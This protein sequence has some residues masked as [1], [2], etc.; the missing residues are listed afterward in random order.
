VDNPCLRPYIWGY[1]ADLRT[2]V[3]KSVTNWTGLRITRPARPGS[4]QGATK[5]MIAVVAVL[6]GCS[7]PKQDPGSEPF[8]PPTR[9]VC[10]TPSATETV[11]AVAGPS[12]IVGI[13]YYSDFPP[14]LTDR[15]RVGEFLSPNLEAI[16]ALRPD[17]VVLDRV[18]TQALSG[19]RAAGIATLDLRMERVAD[20]KRAL[21]RTG[22]AFGQPQRAQQ[23]VSQLERDLAEVATIGQRA[24]RPPRVLFVVDRELGGLR[25]I[26][27]A[28]PHTYLSELVTLAGGTNVLADSPVPFPRISAEEILHER[29]DVILDAVH[30]DTI[31]R[32]ASDWNVLATVPAVQTGRIYVLGEAMHAHPGPRL[33]AT[34]R[35]IA[36]LIH[37]P[38]RPPPRA[39]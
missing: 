20:V 26:T 6:L 27:A 16:L 32:A 25:S 15:P 14:E 11:A 22:A 2:T 21:L 30:T 31:Q 38:G 17:L 33:A 18:Q 13:D 5:A 7:A 3:H 39:P 1:F 4:L 24:P 29:P 34:L 37:R 10:L 28:G 12:V 36:D 35:T 19:L 23:L 9:V 8:R